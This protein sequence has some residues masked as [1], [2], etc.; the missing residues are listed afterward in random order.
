MFAVT[1]LS[2]TAGMGFTWGNKLRFLDVW[3][4]VILPIFT[5]DLLHLPNT[6]GFAVV[7]PCSIKTAALLLDFTCS[8][9][10]PLS[11]ATHC[12]SF[13]GLPLPPQC[14]TDVFRRCFWRRIIR[15]VM[16]TKPETQNTCMKLYILTLTMQYTVVHNQY[17]CS[18]FYRT[19]TV[20]IN[21]LALLQ[22]IC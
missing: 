7:W 19:H 15:S 12:P 9:I 11:A 13:V 2:R 3:S 14:T 6:N 1:L 17:C 10:H 18:P 5:A 22:F 21:L 4:F 16:K 20:S 8:W